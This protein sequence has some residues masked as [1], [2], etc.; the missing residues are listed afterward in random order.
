MIYPAINAIVAV[1]IRTKLFQITLEEKFM[2][3]W[4]APS[5]AVAINRASSTTVN[6]VATPIQITEYRFILLNSVFIILTIFSHLNFR[7]CYKF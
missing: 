4:V 7:V 3:V 1:Y 6:I 2:S 5:E